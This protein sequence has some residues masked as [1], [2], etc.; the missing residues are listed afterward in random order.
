MIAKVLIDLENDKYKEAKDQVGG[1]DVFKDF[2][3]VD[4]VRE[5]DVVTSFYL[6]PKDGKVLPAYQSGQ[7]LTIRVTIPGE[8]YMHIRHYTLSGP[9]NTK[10]FRISVKKEADNEPHGKVSTFLHDHVEI[11]E[12][13]RAHV[14]AGNFTLNEESNPITL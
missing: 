12:I 5:S 2:V 9:S 10:Q 3:V 8:E 11:N 1:R 14:P 13:G 7:Y 4:K 6:E